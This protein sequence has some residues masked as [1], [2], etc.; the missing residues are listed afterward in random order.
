[1]GVAVTKERQT[2]TILVDN[3]DIIWKMFW[4]VAASTAKGGLSKGEVQYPGV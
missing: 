4:L 3:R 1:M 2:A